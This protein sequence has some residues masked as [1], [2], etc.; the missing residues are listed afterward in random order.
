VVCQRVK[1]KVKRILFL[2]KHR[3]PRTDQGWLQAVS[4]GQKGTAQ[5]PA[6]LLPGNARQNL[7]Y[8]ISC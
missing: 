3:G 8:P 1:R 4:S 2:D 7:I 5:R 6:L